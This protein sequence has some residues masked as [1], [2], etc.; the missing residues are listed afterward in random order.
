MA[1]PIGDRFNPVT[2]VASA[3]AVEICGYARKRIF[4]GVFRDELPVKLSTRYCDWQKPRAAQDS[5]PAS[6]IACNLLTQADDLDGR[7]R[8]CLPK[9][10]DPIWQMIPRQRPNIRSISAGRLGRGDLAVQHEQRD[11]EDALTGAIETLTHISNADVQ[12]ESV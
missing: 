7:S 3:A 9:V 5:N 10:P 2:Q 8:P 11:A 6:G 1:G 4:C 12:A